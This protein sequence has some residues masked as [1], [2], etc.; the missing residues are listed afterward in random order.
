MVCEFFGGLGLLVFTV[1]EICLF[2]FSGLEV[3]GFGVC[4]VESWG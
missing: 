1:A 2:W 4:F 3:G